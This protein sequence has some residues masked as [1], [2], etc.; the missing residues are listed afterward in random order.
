MTPNMSPVS[1][2]ASRVRPSTVPSM[3]ISSMRGSCC[4]PQ[5]TSAR[6]P[7]RA[8][9]RPTPP[10]IRPSTALSERNATARRPR[11]APIAER[12]AISRSRPSARTKKTFATLAQAIRRT[13]PTEPSST[14][15]VWATS[16]TSCS[17]RS[18]A[19]AVNPAC[20]RSGA[21]R[22]S[23]S[24]SARFSMRAASW[25]PVASTVI[26]PSSGLPTRCRG[27]R[28]SALRAPVSWARRA[29]RRW[30]ER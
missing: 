11:L 9:T 22:W 14:Q 17:R 24:A 29:R 28:G 4:G 10:A 19:C 7:K 18:M 13:N 1:S 15:R 21:A 20:S 2:D 26:P 5:A 25:A 16:P 6:T 23:G 8:N 30:S 12:M 27:S 3:P